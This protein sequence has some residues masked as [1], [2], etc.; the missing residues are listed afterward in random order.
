FRL[1]AGA[2]RVT[3]LAAM[4]TSG[5]KKTS[6]GTRFAKLTEQS[7][8]CTTKSGNTPLHRAAKLGKLHEIPRHLL[9]IELFLAR[10]LDQQN[11][12]HRTP[13]HLAAM[14]GH[15]SPRIRSMVK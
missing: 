13:L 2:A 1:V 6:G 10:N 15:D 14:Y 12:P 8:R 3:V 9:R 7:I 4:K 11:T 5:V